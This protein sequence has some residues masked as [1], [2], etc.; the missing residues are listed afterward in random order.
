[1]H[2]Y[3]RQQ[4]RMLYRGFD[5]YGSPFDCR[6]KSSGSDKI[7]VKALNKIDGWDMECNTH[8]VS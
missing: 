1:M 8:A 2:F 4:V 5:A 6:L 7:E 3:L